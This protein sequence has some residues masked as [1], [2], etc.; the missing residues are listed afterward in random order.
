M[1]RRTCFIL[2]AL[3]LV[4]PRTYSSSR[5]DDDAPFVTIT[6]DV[7]HSERSAPYPNHS[8]VAQIV[9]FIATIE[10]INHHVQEIHLNS[11]TDVEVTTGRR[12]YWDSVRPDKGDK[13]HIQKRDG[14][15]R[16][17]AKSKWTFDGHMTSVRE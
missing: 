4:A 5:E 16:V 10:G 15:W 13:L 9:R 2:V 12:S 3:A 14:K 7:E 8:K 6:V 17:V 1:L 11:A